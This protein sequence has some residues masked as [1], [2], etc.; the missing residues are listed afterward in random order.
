MRAVKQFLR[1][2]QCRYKAITV[3]VLLRILREQGFVPLGYSEAQAQL[4]RLNLTD[5]AASV[6]AFSYYSG[7]DRL[8]FYNDRAPLCDQL[9]FLSHEEGHI[10]CEHAFKHG[11]LIHTD[12]QKELEANQFTLGL[13]AHNRWLSALPRICGLALLALLVGAGA[14]VWH[15]LRSPGDK[16]EEPPAAA[17]TADPDDGDSDSAS[18]DE[19]SDGSGDSGNSGGD[20]DS[21]G[22]SG[23]SGSDGGSS[24]PKDVDDMWRPEPSGGDD[25]P[26]ASDAPDDLLAYVYTFYFSDYYHAKTCPGLDDPVQKASFHRVDAERFGMQPCPDCLPELVEQNA[27][28][29]KVYTVLGYDGLYHVENCSEIAQYYADANFPECMEADHLSPCPTCNP[30]THSLPL[31]D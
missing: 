29:V 18:G 14:L 28:R 8:V 9:L 24:E 30:P 11:L 5:Y 4:V 2:Y 23:N 26:D 27:Q 6:D 21:D 17:D 25:T 3:P 31:S 13:L 19:D 16:T 20:S 22:D 7:A 12:A 10:F 1:T 15:A